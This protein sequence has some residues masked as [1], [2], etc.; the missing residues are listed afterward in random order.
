MCALCI[1]LRNKFALYLLVLIAPTENYRG[2]RTCQVGVLT[3]AGTLYRTVVLAKYVT[4]LISRV[5]RGRFE[6]AAVK[7]DLS[8]VENKLRKREA[9]ADE[10]ARLAAAR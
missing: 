3:I 4:V 7:S 10:D 8:S 6:L 5:E 2:G 9:K 1:K